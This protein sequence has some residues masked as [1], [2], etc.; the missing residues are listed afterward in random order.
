MDGTTIEAI[1]PLIMAA[2]MKIMKDPARM[3]TIESP[4]DISGGDGD[5]PDTTDKKNAEV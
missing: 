3:A 5:K 2:M 4:G 1:H